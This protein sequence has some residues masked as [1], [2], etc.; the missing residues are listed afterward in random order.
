LVGSYVTIFIVPFAVI[1]WF[2]RAATIVEIDEKNVTLTRTRN[3]FNGYCCL[4]CHAAPTTTISVAEVIDA[5]AVM[6]DACCCRPCGFSWGVVLTLKNGSS[7]ALNPSMDMFQQRAVAEAQK[8]RSA[9]QAS[10]ADT[11]V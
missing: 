9:L 5:Q 8:I 4:A 11:S 6:S 10:R 1:M 2:V 3:P 7:M